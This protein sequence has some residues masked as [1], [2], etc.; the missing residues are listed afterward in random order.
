MRRAP[1]EGAG[2]AWRR[3]GRHEQ[4]LCMKRARASIIGHIDPWLAARGAWNCLYAKGIR[5]AVQSGGTRIRGGYELHVSN[6]R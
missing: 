4:R 3:L 2:T 6:H 5:S 1:G